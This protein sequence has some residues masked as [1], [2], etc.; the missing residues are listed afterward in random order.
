MRRLRLTPGADLAVYYRADSAFHA[1]RPEVLGHVTLQRFIDA[2]AHCPSIGFELEGR[3]IGG[4][5]LDGDEAHIAVLPEAHGQWALLLKPALA[6]L[7]SLRPAVMARVDARNHTCLAFMDRHGWER[8]RADAQSV[9]YLLLPQ[10]GRRKTAYPFRD[11]LPLQSG[12][13]GAERRMELRC[14][15]TTSPARER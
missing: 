13:N 4:I 12:E 2:Y 8:L 11:S 10:D 1:D 3:P 15:S 7:F 14:A 5:L 9:C 6:W